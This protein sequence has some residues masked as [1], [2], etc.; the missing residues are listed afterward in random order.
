M[1]WIEFINEILKLGI[2]CSYMFIFFIAIKVL[3][4]KLKSANAS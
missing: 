1:F 4:T 3:F 2:K